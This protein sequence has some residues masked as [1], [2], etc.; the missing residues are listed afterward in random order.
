MSTTG[1]TAANSVSDLVTKSNAATSTLSSDK[2]TL[3]KD[4]FL[5]LLVTEMEY[6]DPLDPMSNTESIAQLAQFSALEQMENLNASFTSFVSG[7]GSQASNALALN[8]LGFNVT[9]TDSADKTVTDTVTSIT[10]KD[11]AAVLNLKGGTTMNFADVTKV[12]YPA[13]AA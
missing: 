8:T 5:T 3:G 2:N 10:Y 9:G 12:E 6:Q 13:T 11:G 7:L 1:I 4:A